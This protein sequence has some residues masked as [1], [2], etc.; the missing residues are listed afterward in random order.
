MKE[1]FATKIRISEQTFHQYSLSMPDIFH[2]QP[3]G[4]VSR[5]DTL[6]NYNE[7]RMQQQDLFWTLP[8]GSIPIYSPLLYELQWLPVWW[9][10]HCKIL[11]LTFKAVHG[12][13]P[14][15]IC[16]LITIKSKSSYHLRQSSISASKGENA[17]YTW[18]KKIVS[19]NCVS[20]V[21][22]PA[23]LNATNSIAYRF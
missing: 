1:C 5:R 4:L 21:E 17:L 19:C 14:S 6:L 7:Y 10:I 3:P 12:Q 22:Q 11:F 18:S 20:I 16:D 23:C 9:R 15:Y 2:N 13:S 8:L